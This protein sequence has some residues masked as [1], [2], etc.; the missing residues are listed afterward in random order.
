MFEYIERLTESS[1]LTDLAQKVEYRV[2]LAAGS[3]FVI[4]ILFGSWFISW[5]GRRGMLEPEQCWLV[6]KQRGRDIW[7][8]DHAARKP[9]PTMR[10]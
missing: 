2:L 1:L 3:A 10:C 7:E 4:S 5:L 8:Q 9:A 6:A